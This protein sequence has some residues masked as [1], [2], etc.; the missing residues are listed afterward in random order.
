MLGIIKLSYVDLYKKQHKS[1]IDYLRVKNVD[2][3]VFWWDL[4][5]V[6]SFCTRQ[7]T[8][9]MNLNYV[10]IQYHLVIETNVSQ[11][12]LHTN[13]P[14]INNMS[15]SSSLE[16]EFA[17]KI[18]KAA[19]KA[20]IETAVSELVSRKKKHTGKRLRKNNQI[21]NAH[22]HLNDCGIEITK[23][24]LQHRVQR[25]FAQA[26]ASIPVVNVVHSPSSAISSLTA[27]TANNEQ[28]KDE[29]STDEEEEPLVLPDIFICCVLYMMRKKR[30]VRFSLHLIQEW[31]QLI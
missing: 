13:N 17:E 24:A 15:Q 2:F 26:T 30:G 11:D 12:S 16:A 3:Y 31:K 19:A 23:H 21:S 1:S 5:W 9:Q 25:A 27:P 28:N 6:L 10:G 4:K 22:K 8:F 29:D 7:K 18:A 14:K 20:A